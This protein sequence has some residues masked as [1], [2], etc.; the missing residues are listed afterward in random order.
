MSRQYW[1]AVASAD[2]TYAPIRSLLEEL[3]FTAGRKNWGAALR[4]GF[5]E[6]TAEDYERIASTMGVELEGTTVS[7]DPP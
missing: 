5:L 3:S 2:A 4:F 6:I 7:L 1:L